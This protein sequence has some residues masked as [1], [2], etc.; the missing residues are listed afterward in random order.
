MRKALTAT[1][2]LLL[3]TA[4]QAAG[5]GRGRVESTT[6]TVKV[7]RVS[8]II[9]TQ[10]TV[11]GGAIG[12]VVDLVLNEDGCADYLI[13][14]YGS[15]Y[16][17]VP[18]GVITYD[19][20]ASSIV[21]NV[22]VRQEQLRTLVFR[23][24]SWPDFYSDRWAR[25]ART[26]WGER[27]FRRQP[28]DGRPGVD[29]RRGPARRPGDARDD[30]RDGRGDRKD[31]RRDNPPATPRPPETKDRR[32]NPPPPPRPPEKKDRRDD[33]RDDQ[34]AKPRPPEKPVRPEDRDRD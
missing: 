22:N 12:K 7:R 26:V 10:V 16:L 9:G 18:W 6:P 13:V 15:D 23:N 30:R 19:V 31:D 20:G 33:R 11:Q 32:D 8:A 28:R 25:S 27:A 34:P 21:V 24:D 1:L 2:A 4:H 3:L 14:R 29:D 17:P 5:Q